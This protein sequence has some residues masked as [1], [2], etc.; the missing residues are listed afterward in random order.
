MTD[1]RK[2]VFGTKLGLA[3]VGVIFLVCV[4]GL[5][6]LVT[7]FQ[8]GIFTPGKAT[9]VPI[10]INGGTPQ[11]PA[12]DSENQGDKYSISVE[13]SDG[14]SPAADGGSDSANNR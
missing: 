5:V 2:P 7:K 8:P 10:L 9:P 13:L 4:G 1:N 3:L 12:G 11:S 6:L 14:Q